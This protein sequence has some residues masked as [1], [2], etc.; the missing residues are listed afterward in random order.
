M[1]LNS[2]SDVHKTTG[3][4]SLFWCMCV[5]LVSHFFCAALK[6][7]D[8]RA[9]SKAAN[10]Q[11][12]MLNCVVHFPVKCDNECIFGVLFQNVSTCNRMR[13]NLF[14]SDVNYGSMLGNR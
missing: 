5:C 2:R 1:D 9:A 12:G 8:E 7:G 10:E 11:D 6:I 4:G 14:D 3:S 13:V